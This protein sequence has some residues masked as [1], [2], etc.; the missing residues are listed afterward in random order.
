MPSSGSVIT[1]HVDRTTSLEASIK[2]RRRCY[3]RPNP[4]LATA[5]LSTSKTQYVLKVHIAIIP[6]SL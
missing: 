3:L 2:E 4:T 1:N 6:E 5:E